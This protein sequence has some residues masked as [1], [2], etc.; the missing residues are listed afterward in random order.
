MKNGAQ[1]VLKMGPISVR[2]Y[3]HIFATTFGAIGVIFEG[4]LMRNHYFK[5]RHFQI[6]ELKWAPKWTEK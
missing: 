4:C 6:M 2:F 3:G 1:N 5:R